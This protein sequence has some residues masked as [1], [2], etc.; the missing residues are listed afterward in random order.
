MRKRS[1]QT[2][3]DDDRKV[4]GRKIAC[5]VPTRKN[6]QKH[7]DMLT[8]HSYVDKTMCFKYGWAML[9]KK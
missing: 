1:T 9:A 2:R 4:D 3:Q 5:L 6:K 8:V 7:K